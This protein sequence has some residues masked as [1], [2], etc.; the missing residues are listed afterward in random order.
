MPRNSPH[1]IHETRE[2]PAPGTCGV[3]ATLYHHPTSKPQSHLK[4]LLF[5]EAF[6]K[7]SLLATASFYQPAAGVRPCPH[8]PGRGRER[9]PQP[10]SP[11]LEQDTGSLFFP[12]PWGTGCPCDSSPS[13]SP[14]ASNLPVAEFLPPGRPLPNISL[15][16][17]PTGGTSSI[18]AQLKHQLSRARLQILE[19]MSTRTSLYLQATESPLS[20]S[21]VPPHCLMV[22]D[23][24]MKL[25]T[26][27]QGNALE[28]P[29]KALE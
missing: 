15:K 6:L 2:R 24:H 10:G 13:S 18:N 20:T 17:R 27:V 29:L 11:G 1:D 26:L 28:V 7:S 14:A 19:T 21:P 5:H 23:H 8:Q 16:A 12:P 25:G 22:F 3:T 4:S 9:E